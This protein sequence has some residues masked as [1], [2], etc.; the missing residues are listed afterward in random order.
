M[1]TFGSLFTGIGGLDLGLE[2]ARMRCAWQVEIDDYAT[3]VL[4]KH[5]PDVPRFRDVRSV[6][7]HNLPPVDLIAGGFPCQPHSESGRRRGKDDQRDLWPE[8]RRIIRELS[9]RWIMA[10]N[11]P[12]LL[13]SDHGRFFG[14]ILRDL[15]SLGYDAEWSVL[16]ACA[17]GASHT[18][19]RVFLVAYT[20]GI[21]RAGRGVCHGGAART[22]QDTEVIRACW[23]AQARGLVEAAYQNGKGDKVSRIH[24]G[25]H[26]LSSGLDRLRGLGNAVVPQVAEFIGL[27]IVAFDA[28]RQ[29]GS[30]AD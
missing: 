28:T 12:G 22:R 9:P 4:A 2:R 15:A 16:S 6:G 25:T 18:R 19:E 23:S 17:M 24:R 20:N 1:L 8:F 30:A 5:W 7:V 14:G 10:E 21:D 11:V 26:G 29:T 27:Q 13:S 3:R